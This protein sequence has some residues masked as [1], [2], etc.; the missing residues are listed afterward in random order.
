MMKILKSKW[1][2]VEDPWG[3]GT[4]IVAG[5]PDPHIGKFICDADPVR[6]NPEAY[7]NGVWDTEELLFARIRLVM[8]HIVKKY[9]MNG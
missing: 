8:N 1:Y 9:I 4:S 3:D 5:N 2:I 7:L 6:W